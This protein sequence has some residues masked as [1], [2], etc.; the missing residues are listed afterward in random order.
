MVRLSELAAILA[1]KLWPLSASDSQ[2][3]PLAGGAALSHLPP[4]S[5]ALRKHDS[6]PTEAP[7]RRYRSGFRWRADGDSAGDQASHVHRQPSDQA[8]DGDA[9][10]GGSIAMTPHSRSAG[11]DHAPLEGV[12]VVVGRVAGAA[13]PPI[14]AGAAPGPT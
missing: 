8:R 1:A 2:R 5:H 11:L 6:A 14:A 7:S 4:L 9:Q 10:S 3:E 12:L 13:P